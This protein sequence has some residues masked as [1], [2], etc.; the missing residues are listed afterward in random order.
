MYTPPGPNRVGISLSL[1][2]MKNFRCRKSN[3]DSIKCFSLKAGLPDG[4]F[5]GQKS[6]FGFIVEGLQMDN[7]VI[8]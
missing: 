1:F 4:I 8:F 3:K 6:Q 5:L 7:V 2:P